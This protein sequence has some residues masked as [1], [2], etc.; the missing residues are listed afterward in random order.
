[1]NSKPPAWPMP[2]MAGGGTNSDIRFLE[3]PEQ[4]VQP[5]DQRLHRAAL[6]RALRPRLQ[7]DEARAGVGSIDLG[8][9]IQP[10]DGEHAFHFRLLQDHGANLLEHLLGALQRCAGRQLRD[11]EH[12]PLVILGQKAAGPLPHQIASAT[13]MATNAPIAM[14][15]RR[16]AR[17]T[18]LVYFLVARGNNR[19]KAPKPRPAA[20]WARSRERGLSSS[21]HKAGVKVSAMSAEI[22][23]DTDSVSANCL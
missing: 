20:R 2:G 10:R 3:R 7:G 1:M 18:V 13:M 17:R 6:A 11:H 19:L 8:K 5:S 12:V 22:S 16:M 14:A 15:E 9:E 21:A 4:P 23:T